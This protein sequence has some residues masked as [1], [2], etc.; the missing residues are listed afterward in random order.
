MPVKSKQKLGFFL[1]FLF[2]TVEKFFVENSH[3]HWM[4]NYTHCIYICIY[5]YIYLFLYICIFIHL[6]YYTFLLTLL[7]FSS[8]FSEEINESIKLSKIY[9]VSLYQQRTKRRRQLFDGRKILFQICFVVGWWQLLQVLKGDKIYI[10]VENKV[11][12]VQEKSEYY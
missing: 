4:P 2:T 12:S 5:I 8:A 10:F 9:L 1:S 11:N 6:H 3:T 7:F